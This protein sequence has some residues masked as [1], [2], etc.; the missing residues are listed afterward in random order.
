MEGS[1]DESW[2]RQGV[3]RPAAVAQ[4]P[5]EGGQEEGEERQ[6]VAGAQRGA[7]GAAGQEAEQ[8]GD[9]ILN[10]SYYLQNRLGNPSLVPR[11][12]TATLHL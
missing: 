12:M 5:E 4:E 10:W 7:E 2:R 6:G 11:P 8:V 9:D 3:G 1:L